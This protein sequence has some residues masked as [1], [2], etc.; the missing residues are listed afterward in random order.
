LTGGDHGNCYAGNV[1]SA[2]FSL[3]GILPPCPWA[4]PGHD[5]AKQ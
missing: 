4:V 5:P 2:F 1:F 3:L